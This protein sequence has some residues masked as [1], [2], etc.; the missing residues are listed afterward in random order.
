MS[1]YS[2]SNSANSNKRTVYPPKTPSLTQPG[3]VLPLRTLID[4]HAKGMSVTQYNPVYTDNVHLPDNWE[5]MTDIEKYEFRQEHDLTIKQMRQMLE[6]YAKKTP[7]SVAEPAAPAKQG[8]P[9]R[10]DE[11]QA[12]KAPPS[13]EQSTKR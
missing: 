10:D 9:G 13:T 12:P 6:A 7:S 4:R 2:W 3:L 5:R 11:G 8:P 1:I